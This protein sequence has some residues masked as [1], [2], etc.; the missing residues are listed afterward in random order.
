VKTLLAASSL[1]LALL[2][3][4]VTPPREPQPGDASLVPGD[5]PVFEQG[6]RGLTRA[7]L[8]LS[9]F[10]DEL[11][12]V[13]RDEPVL[14][15]HL[16]YANVAARANPGVVNIY[17]RKLVERELKIGFELQNLLPFELP[18]VSKLL[19]YIPFQVPVPFRDEGLALGSGFVVNREGYLLTNAHVIQNATDVIVVFSDRREVPARIVG[20][21]PL[22]DT[23]LL[24]V[25]PSP[26]LEPLPF[27]SSTHLE[28]GELVLAVGNP[29]GL[30]HSVTSGLVSATERSIPGTP[31][32]LDF[33]QTDS[34]INPG[35]SG[36]PLLNLHGEVIGMNTA[37]LHQAQNIGFAVPIDTV[38]TVIPLLL[39]AKTDRGWLGMSV[40]FGDDRMPVVDAVEKDSPAG[41]AG[42]AVGDRVI[43]LN[44]E[45]I[46]GIVPLRRLALGLVVG[47]EVEIVVD[48]QGER[49]TFATVLAERPD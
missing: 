46:T 17:T 31:E 20:A 49:H 44:G 19:S 3:C 42:I 9:D 43:E 24:R 34:A 5:A 6:L 45:P 21:D 16:T 8:D 23:A 41:R 47:D 7:D 26:A 38:K 37:V 10:W 40:G 35:N 25:A 32:L 4:T 11:P 28:V 18:I 33:V 30:S 39:M 13:E 15:H 2:A 48:R 12:D 29:L 1:A 22:T 36:G 27:G 14:L